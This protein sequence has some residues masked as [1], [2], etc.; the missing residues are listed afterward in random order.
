MSGA[1]H[2]EPETS[3]EEHAEE[4]AVKRKRGVR[5]DENYKRNVIKKC[6]VQGKAYVNYKGKSVAARKVGEGCR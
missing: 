4:A 5:N 3:L 2:S 6:R 1:E